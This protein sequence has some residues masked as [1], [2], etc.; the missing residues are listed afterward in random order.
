MF[1]CLGF[2]V[3]D[4]PPPPPPNGYKVYSLNRQEVTDALRL[5]LKD[6]GLPITGEVTFERDP[7]FLLY[8]STIVGGDPRSTP[9]PSANDIYLKIRV[10]YPAK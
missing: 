7:G 5:W 4:E 6:K 8:S 2:D 1:A 10:A 3:V 9:K